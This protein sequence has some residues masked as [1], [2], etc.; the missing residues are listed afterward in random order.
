L[1]EFKVNFNIITEIKTSDVLKRNKR[2][3]FK[4][5]KKTEIEEISKVKYN[6]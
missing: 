2:R 1:E 4:R 3:K 5:E 6:T